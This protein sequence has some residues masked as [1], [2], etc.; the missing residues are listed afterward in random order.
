L[1]QL[2]EMLAA[3]AA[4]LDF[5]AALITQRCF[6]I[7]EFRYKQGLGRPPLGK[8]LRTGDLLYWA[9]GIQ[10]RGLP[11]M[12]DYMEQHVAAADLPV[13]ERLARFR[14]IEG[15]LDRLSLLHVT[16]KTWLPIFS[17]STVF[18]VDPGIRV[19]SD[20]AR[21]ALAIERFRLP[22]DELPAH[23][24]ELVPRYLA[25]VPL[26][27]FDGQPVRYRRR[28]AGYLLYSVGA[29]GQDNDGR[30]QD[31]VKSGEPRDSCFIVIR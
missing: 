26:D 6:V 29:D 3:S 12:L 31:E 7:E 21:T 24:E 22:T 8:M 27:P 4:C 9:P 10:A 28:P 16:A 15:E 2:D 18:E 20:L 19:Q 17:S 1:T 13:L 30:E 5:R 23:L 14:A 25:Q 11:D